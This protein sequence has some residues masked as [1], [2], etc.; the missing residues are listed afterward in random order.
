VK[1]F[2]TGATGLVGRAL[3]ASLVEAGEEVVALTRGG[4]A[5]AGLPV[6]VRVVTGDPARAGVWLDA[7]AG[8]DACVHLAGEPVAGGRWTPARKASIERSR[9]DSAALVAGLLAERGP[10]ILV[11]GS[12]VGYYGSRGEERL[13]ESSAPGGDFL[14]GVTARW[15][16]AAAPARRRARVVLLRTG[17]VLAR[18]GGALA[19]LVKPFRL[20][21]GGPV[22]SPSAWKPWI[23]VA[24]E[25]GLIRF[26]LGEAR[27][28]GAMNGCAPEPARN[29]ELARAIGAA[30]SRPSLL[31]APAFVLRALLGELADVV[32]ASQ[33]AVPAKALALGYRFRFPELR[34]ALRDLLG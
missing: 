10:R 29:A 19:E 7:L 11:Q 21:A 25:V 8:C 34:G 13:D 28:E 12:A 16:A 1:I 32:L 27:A 22:G 20:F 24:D 15:E 2:I 9:V 6:P 30:L 4:A 5:S 31:P 18:E 33:R 23:H 14:A 26:A 17:M 3:C